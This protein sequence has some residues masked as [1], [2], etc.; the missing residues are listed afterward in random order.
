MSLRRTARG[1]GIEESLRPS[2]TSRRYATCGPNR[3]KELLFADQSLVGEARG[4]Y[5]GGQKIVSAGKQE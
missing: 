2:E 3:G 1:G 4:F 5:P